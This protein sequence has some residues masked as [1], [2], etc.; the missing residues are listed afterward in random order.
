MA[1][2]ELIFNPNKSVKR[3]DIIRLGELI[4]REAKKKEIDALV[5]IVTDDTGKNSASI[6]IKIVD[7][8]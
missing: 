3:K 7:E 5:L 4:A 6:P 8:K 1:N 2:I